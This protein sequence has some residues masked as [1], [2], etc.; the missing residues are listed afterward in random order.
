MLPSFLATLHHRSSFL[1]ELIVKSSYPNE[2]DPRLCLKRIENLFFLNLAISF[3][4]RVI[5]I[6]LYRTWAGTILVTH[7]KDLP[8]HDGGLGRREADVVIDD[9]GGGGGVGRGA[10]G[11]HAGR[12]GRRQRHPL[13]LRGLQVLD[14]ARRGRRRRPSRALGPT[15]GLGPTLAGGAHRGAAAQHQP[16]PPHLQHN[17]RASS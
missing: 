17:K 8:L 1:A 4:Y 12:T 2:V 13:A 16:L 11:G 6:P 5:A 15:R 3:G 10:A 9:G 14:G 7:R